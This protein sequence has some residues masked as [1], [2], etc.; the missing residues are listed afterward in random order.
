MIFIHERTEMVNEALQDGSL[1]VVSLA[2]EQ[3]HEEGG[4]GCVGED[5]GEFEQASGSVD[6]RNGCLMKHNTM[7]VRER[8]GLHLCIGMYHEVGK[9]EIKTKRRGKDGRGKG[10]GEENRKRERGRRFTLIMRFALKERKSFSS[11]SSK[12]P[13][14]SFPLSSSFL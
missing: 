10:G 3:A 13:S 11:L 6:G 2:E 1:Q 7:R 9:K 4:C 8:E 14:P 5:L 12:A